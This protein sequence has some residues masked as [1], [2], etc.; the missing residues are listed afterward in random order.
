M[1]ERKKKHMALS[2]EWSPSPVVVV[3][4]L[5]GDTKPLPL[6]DWLVSTIATSRK[7]ERLTVNTNMTRWEAHNVAS[8]EVS[9][10]GNV[11]LKI[12]QGRGGSPSSLWLL[13][14]PEVEAMEHVADGLW[15]RDVGR[16]RGT[17]SKKNL[18]HQMGDIP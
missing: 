9:S 5:G 10:A 12:N 14:M 8:M 2:P 7:S 4:T 17:W 13:D 1:R 3:V 16:E 11:N 18:R 6:A 15:Q